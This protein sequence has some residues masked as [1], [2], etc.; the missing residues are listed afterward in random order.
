MTLP[1]RSERVTGSSSGSRVASLRML[2]T[3]RSDLPLRLVRVPAGQILGDRIQILDAPV[4][5][6]RDHG[7]A[8]RLQ[9]DLRLLLLLEHRSLGALALAD[10]GDRAFVADQIAVLVAH[11]ARALDHRQRRAVDA[12]Q[13]ELGVADLAVAL[14]RRDDGD[15]FQRVLIDRF[16]RQRQQLARRR[17]ADHARERRD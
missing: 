3:S 7:V 8:D 13:L 17:E 14:E 9:R 6:R 16:G 15:A 10:V 11:G 12:S 2:K 4:G 1:S 5:V